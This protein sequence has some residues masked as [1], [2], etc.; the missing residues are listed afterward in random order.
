MRV[1]GWWLVLVLAGVACVGC[2]A[3]DDDT[4]EGDDDDVA[5]DPP[6][7]IGDLQAEPGYQ[8]ITLTWN[9][10]EHA[11]F[12]GV[13]IRRSADD[14]PATP[15]GDDLVYDGE[16]EMVIDDLLLPGVTYFYAAFSHDGQGNH[17]SAVTLSVFLEEVDI[18]PPAPASDLVVTRHPAELEL[19]WDNPS[20]PDLAGVAVR[21]AEGAPPASID[22]GEEVYDGLGEAAVD[23]GVVPGITYHYSAFAYD[24]SGNVADPA[25]ADGRA[26]YAIVGQLLLDEALDDHFEEL[27]SSPIDF[28][29]YAPTVTEELVEYD[30]WG[31]QRIRRL[32][33]SAVELT[34]PDQ[35]ALLVGIVEDWRAGSALVDF[36]I[37]SDIDLDWV[38]VELAGPGDPYYLLQLS[39]EDDCAEL[40]L[41]PDGFPIAAPLSCD[42][43][44]FSLSQNVGS[45]AALHISS[46]TGTFSSDLGS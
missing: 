11:A 24:A 33:L 21:R 3:D 7:P 20:D 46:G 22:D 5:V 4:V 29:I 40:A 2:P 42:T 18:Q 31:L 28:E 36:G 35:P 37:W 34:F 26:G 39:A 12:A 1:A 6:P 15:G 44:V 13:V 17:S 30:T 32:H 14:Y 43:A 45:G 10:P 23:A 27:L 41:D 25:S 19:S 9:N 38:E 8:Q 16:G